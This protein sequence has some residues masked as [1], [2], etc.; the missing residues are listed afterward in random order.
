MENQ[1]IRVLIFT[2]GIK[3]RIEILLQG[4]VINMVRLRTISPA[5]SPLG[6]DIRLELRTG[7]QE[8]VLLVLRRREEMELQS[9]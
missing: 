2:P 5:I 7:A 3:I 9:K 8:D 1:R 4:K 6:I